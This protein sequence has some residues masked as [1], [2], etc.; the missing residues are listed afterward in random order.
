[1]NAVM[2]IADW[3]IYRFSEFRIPASESQF[4]HLHSD[5]QIQETRNSQSGIYLR[6]LIFIDLFSVFRRVV[7]GFGI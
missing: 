4:P 6:Q 2:E 3:L 7:F 5:F 1:L